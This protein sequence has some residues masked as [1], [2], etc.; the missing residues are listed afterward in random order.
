MPVKLGNVASLLEKIGE[1]PFREFPIVPL[2]QV[3]P[4]AQQY[5][6]GE[7]MGHWHPEALD[8]HIVDFILLRAQEWIDAQ[9]VADGRR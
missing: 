8:E 4:G 2:K 3:F 6:R 5:E 1:P 9:L 7:P